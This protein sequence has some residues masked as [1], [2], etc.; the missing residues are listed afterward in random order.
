VLPTDPAATPTGPVP[1]PPA[2]ATPGGGAIVH[3]ATLIIH[4]H[5]GDRSLAGAEVSVVADLGGGA[6]EA[7]QTTTDADGVAVLEDLPYATGGA[8]DPVWEVTA[9]LSTEEDD[10]ACRISAVYTG[11][12][13]VTASPGVSRIELPV[14]E[15]ISSIT[16]DLVGRV[17]G[18]DDEPFEVD[19]AFVSGTGP[20]GEFGFEIE[21]DADGDFRLALP[22]FHDALIEIAGV[23]WE[24]VDGDCVT[25]YALY[26]RRALEE[27]DPEAAAGSRIIMRARPVQVGISCGAVPTVP[28]GGDGGGDGG[29]GTGGSDGSEAAPVQPALTPP[30]TDTVAGAPESGHA[31]LGPI[32]VLLGLLAVALGGLGWH[33]R[34]G[35]PLR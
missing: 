33:R 21:V 26:A 10:G 3:G 27:G 28:A 16:C 30:L 9:R 23:R 22:A 5:D 20:D 32:L 24:E 19:Y 7:F 18:P 15:A 2:T 17:L 12:A 8:D 14:T 4:F 25:T 13:S 34:A 11:R 6:I 29:G 35:V 31:P 1:T